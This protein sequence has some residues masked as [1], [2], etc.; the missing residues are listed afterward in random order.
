[1]NTAKK[2][3]VGNKIEESQL[4][5]DFYRQAKV[6]VWNFILNVMGNLEN[7]RI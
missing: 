7:K 3:M 1:M 5:E 4:R 2:R 6:S